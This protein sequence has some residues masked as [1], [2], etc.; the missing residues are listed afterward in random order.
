[1]AVS[2]ASPLADV[3]DL[4]KAKDRR[5]LARLQGHLGN[6]TS[7]EWCPHDTDIVLTCADDGR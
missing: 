4:R 2:Y 7:I 5:P 3:W 1:M 6:V